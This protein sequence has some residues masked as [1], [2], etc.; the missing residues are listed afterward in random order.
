MLTQKEHFIMK[1]I[2]LIVIITQRITPFN[3]LMYSD[4]R[5]RCEAFYHCH[6]ICIGTATEQFPLRPLRSHLVVARNLLSPN[7][8]I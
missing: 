1:W 3:Y 4:S 7:T 8:F 5:C 6:A 2:K